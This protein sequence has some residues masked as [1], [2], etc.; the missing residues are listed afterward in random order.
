MRAPASA[1][2]LE[3]GLLL[4]MLGQSEATPLL[5]GVATGA[6]DLVLAGRALRA[7][8]AFDDANDVLRNAAARTPKDPAVNTA[9]G[10]LYLDA[11]QKADK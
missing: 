2:A 1:A 4:Q 5:R 11:H 8:G 7:L 6:S 10:E 3:L 9:W